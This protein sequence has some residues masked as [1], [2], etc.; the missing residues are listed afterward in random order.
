MKKILGSFSA[1]A[2]L[3][4]AC[5]SARATL[6]TVDVTGSDGSH[7]T[8]TMASSS[9]TITDLPN[10][11]QQWKGTTSKPGS[12][13]LQWDLTL[14]PDPSVSGSVALT[15]ASATTQTFTL[16]VSLPIAPTVAAG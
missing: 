8:D 10:G 14:D 5:S 11:V 1:I 12:Y 4:M 6:F 16:N 13:T 9:G 7:T 3:L 15:N 2:I